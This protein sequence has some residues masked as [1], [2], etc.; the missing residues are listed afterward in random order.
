MMLS[1]PETQ[2]RICFPATNGQ[3]LPA[4]TGNETDTELRE[5]ILQMARHCRR[6]HSHPICQF[7]MML[8]LSFPAMQ[9]LLNNLS[10]AAL[11]DILKEECFCRQTHQGQNCQTG[12]ADSQAAAQPAGLP[13]S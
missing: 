1:W 5:L 4:F 8:G 6:E 13:A 11:L 9:N 10:R 2:R 12:G 7:R 3:Y